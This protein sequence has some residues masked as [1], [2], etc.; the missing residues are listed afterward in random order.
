[1]INTNSIST[2][3]SKLELELIRTTNPEVI[4][5]VWLNNRTH[6]A[7][8]IPVDVWLEKS[9]LRTN[10][11]LGVGI[12]HK[13]WVLVPKGK[14]NDPS[15][16]LSAVHTYER[17]GLMSDIRPAM[18]NGDN[19]ATPS[20][21]VHI[22][23]VMIVY[24]LLVFTPVE[25]RKRGYARKM[26]SL[27]WDRLERQTNPTVSHSFLY[28]SVGP[29]FYEASGWPATRSRELVMQVPGHIFPDLPRDSSTAKEYQLEDITESNLQEILDEDAELLR[30]D[31]RMKA[32][33]AT[34]NQCFLAI[35]PEARTF[36]GHLSIANFTNRRIAMLNKSITRIGVRLISVEKPKN[37]HPFII[38]TYL[39]PHK[40]LLILRTRY[41]TVHQLQSLL[42]EAM[43]ESCEW[44]MTTMSLWDLN[45][46]DALQ[47]TG[48][49]NKNRTI[50]WS[51][52]GQF[53][54]SDSVDKAEK[55]QSDIE[56]LL[57]EAYI[58]GL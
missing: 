14:G 20:S 25:H 33:A 9:I 4:K 44:D 30:L 50:A 32:Q 6:F 53:G 51:C 18:D 37:R 12:E 38:W 22:N 58:W 5:Q 17:P 16:I 45:E 15:A 19:E 57:N 43:K 7:K 28:S 41:E 2:K 11:D 42:K 26:L 52:V 46:E 13:I 54:R 27:L 34:T 36:R 3:E 40:L 31:M 23:D 55:P 24:I 49:P 47:A 1:M 21:R 29:S 10:L 48:I 56:L 35:L 8:E 39:V